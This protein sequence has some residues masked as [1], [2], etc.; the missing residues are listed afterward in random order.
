MLN[1]NVT[2]SPSGAAQ[3]K[4]GH[5]KSLFA[6]GAPM[7]TLLALAWGCAS[8]LVF[9]P[10]FVNT[11]TGDVFPLTPGDRAGF[12]LVRGNNSTPQAIEFVVTAER[13]VLSEENPDETT[14]ITET[15][16]LLTQPQNQANDL[17]VL[18]ECPVL[19]VGLGENIDRPQSEPGLFIGAT[20]VGVGGFGVPSGIN[21]LDSEF[22]NF[23]CGDTIV[24]RAAEAGGSV[25]GV[26]VAAFVLDDE[27]Q[28]DQIQGIDTFVNTRTLIE[29]Q[30]LESD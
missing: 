24:Y 27:T 29:E 7:V 6:W 1:S 28:P 21:P 3:R 2:T 16:N 13:L 15:Y 17:G 8:T 18:I 9:N 26:V 10:A 30:Q 20:A 23:D 5:L 12:V 25:G 4:S 14:V 22:G 11:A 19:R